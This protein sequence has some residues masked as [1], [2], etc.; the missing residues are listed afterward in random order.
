MHRRSFLTGAAALTTASA[1]PATAKAKRAL[2]SAVDVSKL[3][4]IDADLGSITAGSV[5]INSRL[6]I[7]VD[8]TLKIYDAAG[9]LRVRVGPW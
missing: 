3:T 5:V 2:P 1:V 7:D 4:A 6:V 9:V 8:G